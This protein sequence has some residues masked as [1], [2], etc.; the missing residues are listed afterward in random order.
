LQFFPG[1]R[2][3]SHETLPSRS[4]DRGFFNRGAETGFQEVEIAAL[5]G[6]LNVA[7]EHPAIAPLEAGFRRLPFG[8]AL[9]QLR[10]G[11]IETDA[12]RRDVERDPVAVT[13]QRQ[14]SAYVGFR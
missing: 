6:L 12:A 3:Q 10:F 9:C 5:V 1:L 7:R 14:R 8:P 11:H 4:I 2:L 13:H